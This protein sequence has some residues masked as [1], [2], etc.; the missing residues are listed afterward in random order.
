MNYRFTILLFSKNGLFS[1]RIADGSDLGLIIDSLVFAEANDLKIEVNF[2]D[3]CG[4]SL[5]SDFRK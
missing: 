1:S 2:S 5:S 3:F 4:L